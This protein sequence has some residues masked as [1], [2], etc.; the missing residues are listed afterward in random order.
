MAARNAALA[1]LRK[2]ALNVERA[3]TISSNPRAEQMFPFHTV[4][5]VDPGRDEVEARVSAG[6]RPDH[7][8]AFV[9]DW[10]ETRE[11]NAIDAASR[12]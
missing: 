11:D 5:T 2:G 4:V 3:W 10:Y 1:S 6:A 7:F 9:R 8:F 12:R